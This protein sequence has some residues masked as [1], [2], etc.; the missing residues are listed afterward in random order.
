MQPLPSAPPVQNPVALRTGF[1]WGV[2]IVVVNI[3]LSYIGFAAGI[4]ALGILTFIIGLVGFFLAG[5]FAARQ[6]GRVETGLLAGLYAGIV[7]GI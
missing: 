1:L 5:M 4:S 7:G 3:I 2:I 6:T